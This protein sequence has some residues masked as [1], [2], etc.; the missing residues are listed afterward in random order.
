MWEF[1]SSRNSSAKHSAI[2]GFICVYWFRVCAR[3]RV[4]AAVFFPH[5]IFVSQR[6]RCSPYSACRARAAT[7]W[8]SLGECGGHGPRWRRTRGSLPKAHRLPRPSAAPAAGAG[9]RRPSLSRTPGCGEPPGE[10]PPRALSRA[11][12]APCAWL[13]T[14]PEVP[15]SPGLRPLPRAV[16][17]G[18]QRYSLLFLPRT[19]LVWALPALRFVPP[20][21]GRKRSRTLFLSL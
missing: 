7:A 4:T 2:P 12:A 21:T 5:L 14:C 3:A 10:L 20:G 17:A 19:C 6:P 15:G 8:V 1:S 11:L 13:P 16:A 9:P 18:G